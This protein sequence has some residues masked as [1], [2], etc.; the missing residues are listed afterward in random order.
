MVFMSLSRAENEIKV[1]FESASK[2]E[3]SMKYFLTRRNMS[4]GGAFVMKTLYN[5]I[6]THLHTKIRIL[7]F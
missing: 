7:F 6:T 5:I 4:D 1:D 2:V 3:W